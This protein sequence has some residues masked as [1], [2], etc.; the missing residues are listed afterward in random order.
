MH[1]LAQVSVQS[2][3]LG[4]L[5]L[6]VL[7]AAVAVFVASSVVWMVLPYHK[8]DIR[9]MDNEEGFK[10][11]IKPLDL[12]PGLYMYPNCA[13]A[14]DMKS[15]SYKERFEAGPW[16]V[17]TVYPGKPN[18]GA[19]LLKTFVMYLIISVFVAYMV[20]LAAPAGAEYMRVFR[21]AATAGIMAHCLG[22][23]VN[24][25]FLGKPTRFV[26]TSLLDGVIYALVTA[27]VFAA[28]WPGLD[29]PAIPGT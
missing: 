16:G 22:G 15:E 20:S 6:P 26:V 4:E 2:V 18:F 28:M 11:A 24:D 23:I 29:A 25:I 12:A 9:F 8:A 17:I 19:N 14:K 13:D 10:E 5:W 27:G 21:I 3:S 7:I 1:T